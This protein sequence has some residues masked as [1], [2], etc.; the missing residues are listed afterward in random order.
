MP[1][2]FALPAGIG[3]LFIGITAVWMTRYVLRGRYSG[4]I[5]V[6]WNLLGVRDFIVAVATGFAFNTPTTYPLVLIPGFLVPL[7]LT[8][9][10]HSLRKLAR[11]T[12]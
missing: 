6:V 12:V 5:V 3:D 4:R 11:G 10:F 2:G 7:A 1:G 8:F 9:H